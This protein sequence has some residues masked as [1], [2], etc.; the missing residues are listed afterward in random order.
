MEW[1]AFTINAFMN[2][3][4]L[5]VPVISKCSGVPISV[6]YRMKAGNSTDPKYNKQL[7]AYLEAVK[8]GRILELEEM[9]KYYENFNI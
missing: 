3:Y 2:H 7:D 8:K 6:L 5:T 1:D 4:A 9:I